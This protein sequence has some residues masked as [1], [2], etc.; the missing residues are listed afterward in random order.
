MGQ[1]CSDT[2]T[3]NFEDVQVPKEN[4]LAAPGMGFKVAMGAFDSIFFLKIHLI[5]N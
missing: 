4:V 2:R 5:K 3:I 1:R